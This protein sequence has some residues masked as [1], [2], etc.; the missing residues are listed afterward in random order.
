MVGG[1]L[2]EYVSVDM[3]TYVK[4]ENFDEMVRALK[5]LE[6][7]GLP[8]SYV[9]DIY[10]SEEENGDRKGLLFCCYTNLSKPF[11]DLPLEIELATTLAKYSE[12]LHL[13]FSDLDYY[14]EYHI[15]YDE[16]DK[17]AKTLVRL[18]SVLTVDF[19]KPI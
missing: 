17:H 13:V 11:L 15:S 4:K 18:R 12:I 8:F 1:N 6:D 9:D 14:A 7:K 3:N 19:R 16:S 2:M 5:L 10:T